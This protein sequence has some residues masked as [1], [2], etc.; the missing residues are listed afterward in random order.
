MIGRFI[1]VEGVE[2]CGKSTQ[3]RLLEEHL[4]GKGH[5]VV[6]TRE[7]GGPPIAET[8]R[9][10]LLD[11]ANSALSPTTELLLYEAARAQHVDQLIRPALESGNIVL[12]DRFADSTTAY[13]GA[14]RGLPR[15]TVLRLHQVATRGTWPDLT[16]VLDLPPEE[17]LKRAGALGAPDRLE[18]EPLEFHQRVREGFLELAQAEPDRVKVIDAAQAIERV[19]E[20]ISRLVDA[21]VGPP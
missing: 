3:L 1:T 2:G 13:Q 6:V 17:G 19:A 11:P 20:E 16:I 7:P 8:I 14:A 18:K 9:R 21:L 12:C 10:I 5:T 4:T 15:E